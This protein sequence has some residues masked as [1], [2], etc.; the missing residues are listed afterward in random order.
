MNA[1]VLKE[2]LLD[3]MDV[4]M[5]LNPE[6]ITDELL[7]EIHTLEPFGHGNHDPVFYSNNFSIIDSKVVGNGKHLKLTLKD[8]HSRSFDGIGFNLGEK[9]PL[10]Y[11]TDHHLLFK[12][13]FNEWGG[14]TKI[15]LM[16]RTL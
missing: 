6:V 8:K 5:T 9:L 12:L 7:H 16:T 1:T 15:Q 13:E 3:T 10:V 2:S 11:K 4:D 14:Q